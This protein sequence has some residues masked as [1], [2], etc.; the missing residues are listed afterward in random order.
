MLEICS[1]VSNVLFNSISNGSF[2]GLIYLIGK[3]KKE[4]PNVEEKKTEFCRVAV[5]LK[6]ADFFER[7]MIEKF[8][9]N[10]R[11]LWQHRTRTFLELSSFSNC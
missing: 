5:D 10:K 6:N 2:F 1:I 9:C 4:M 8:V 7:Q 11:I 3:F